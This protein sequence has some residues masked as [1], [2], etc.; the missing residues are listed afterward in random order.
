[1]T[2]LTPDQIKEAMDFMEKLI[3]QLGRC[4]SRGSEMKAVFTDYG[5]GH[6]RIALEEYRKPKTVTREWVLDT[7]HRIK[8]AGGRYKTMTEALKELGIEVV[9]E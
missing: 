5:L 1:M 6:L 3:Y 2:N 7:V 4:R 8:I 9:D